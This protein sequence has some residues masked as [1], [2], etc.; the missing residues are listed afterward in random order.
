MKLKAAIDVENLEDFR[1]YYMGS[2]VQ[3]REDPSIIYN[4]REV[5]LSTNQILLASL[6]RVIGDDGRELPPEPMTLC[7]WR[8]LP[9]KI[10]FGT[11]YSNMVAVHG[12][13]FWLNY[14]EGRSPR[15]GLNHDQ[16]SIRTLGGTW[17]EPINKIMHARLTP[18]S[19]WFEESIFRAFN[20][21]YDRVENYTA[22]DLAKVGVALHRHYAVAPSDGYLFA[23]ESSKSKYPLFFRRQKIIGYYNTD[24]NRAILDPIH[25]LRHHIFIENVLGIKCHADT[26]T[27]K[28]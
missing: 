15:R 20:P 9:S 11:V 7:S 2:Y 18:E 3:S 27:R 24:T 19:E 26:K 25:H 5:S 23:P 14:V 28:S 1:K 4:I 10:V 8:D 21:T 13:I 22:K 17:P 16:H 6:G 12:R